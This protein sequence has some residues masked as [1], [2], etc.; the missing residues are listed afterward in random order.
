MRTQPYAEDFYSHRDASTRSSAKEVVP[1]V[2]DLLQ[3]KSVIDVGCGVGTWLSVFKDHGVEDIWGL[4]GQWVD[5]R[6][7]EIPGERFI[8]H[9]LR[10]PLSL[11]RRFDLVVSLEVAEHLPEE[12]ARTF[13]DSLAALGPVILFSAAIPFQRGRNHINTQWPEYWTR[14]FDEKGYVV[15]DCIRKKIWNNQ[16]VTW[17]YRQNILMYS[18]RDHLARWPLLERAFANN[19]A[20]QLSV[21][22]PSH[23]LRRVSSGDALDNM[24]LKTVIA[25][26]PELAKNALMRRMRKLSSA[27]FHPL[28]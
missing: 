8:A 24:A 15:V 12:C 9:D 17:V 25:A 18:R 14:H 26:L 2:L 28:R 13:I 16:N 21:V 20:T 27:L 6:L 1:A 10:T 7:L 22:H 23:Y 4:D 11:D 19:S 3:P 5:R